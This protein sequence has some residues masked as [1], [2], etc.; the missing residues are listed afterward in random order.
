[1]EGED[2]GVPLHHD[3]S[4]LLGDRRPRPVEPVDDRP[5]AEEL[6]LGRVDV[7]RRNRVVVVQPAR[8]E[9]DDPSTRVGEREDEPAR[10]VVVPASVHE[11]G[12]DELLLGVALRVGL[13]GE[14]GAARREPEPELAADLL[15]EPALGEVRAHRRA[16]VG[17]PQVADVERR[18]LLEERE[19]ALAPLADG[20]DLR[21]DLLV[22][23]RDAIAVG[24]PFDRPDEVEPFGLADERDQVAT[25]V[26]PVAV[27]ELSRRVHR[28]A[29]RPLLVE[30]TA[31]RPPRADAAQRR[32]RRDDLDDVGRRLHLL[33][34]GVGD[35]RHASANRSVI[36][37]T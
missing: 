9:A 13:R 14:D 3:G 16:R 36:P 4:V 34:R 28:E 17:L 29:R 33:D 22:L 32:A 23:E 37:E 20:L 8:A 24:Q 1:M 26:A 10:E 35:Y 12:G 21:G 5:L 15:A 19:Q 2:V 27:E 11:P 31:A 6:A 30:G 7:L 18:R 25:L